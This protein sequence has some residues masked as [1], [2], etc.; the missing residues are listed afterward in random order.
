M[1]FYKHKLLYSFSKTDLNMFRSN[2][3]HHY[4]MDFTDYSLR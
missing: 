1:K 3:V 4:H 2:F